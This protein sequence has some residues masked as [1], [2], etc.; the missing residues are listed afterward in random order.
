MCTYPSCSSLCSNFTD[1]DNVPINQRLRARRPKKVSGNKTA[2]PSQRI[3]TNKVEPV[4]SDWN[5]LPEKD[6]QRDRLGFNPYIYDRTSSDPRF[7]CKMHQVM[8]EFVINR[9][10]NT[11]VPQQY[12]DVE[13]V[14]QHYP[15]T[16]EILEFHN[17]HRLMGRKKDYNPELI[18]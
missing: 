9:K 13:W 8:Y 4:H 16:M 6:F 7:Y 1:S 17:L 3:V 12:L 14:R 2:G 18:K 10:E 15:E 5:T 11:Y